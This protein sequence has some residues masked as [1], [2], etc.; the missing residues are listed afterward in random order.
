M[1]GSGVGPYQLWPASS[2]SILRRSFSES[3]LATVNAISWSLNVLESVHLFVVEIS[4]SEQGRVDGI[5]NKLWQAR[6]DERIAEETD[7]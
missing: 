3:I 5:A 4:D 2:I 6:T 7:V 1:I